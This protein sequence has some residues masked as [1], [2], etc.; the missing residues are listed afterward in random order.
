LFNQQQQ[1]EI[2]SAI[3]GLHLRDDTEKLLGVISRYIVQLLQPTISATLGLIRL[4]NAKK[5]D[6]EKMRLQQDGI[7]TGT[8]KKKRKYESRNPFQLLFPTETQAEPVPVISYEI[9]Y[10]CPAVTTQVL[11]RTIDEA[12]CSV[13]QLTQIPVNLLTIYRRSVEH[14]DTYEQIEELSPHGLNI[15]TSK[16]NIFSP[17]LFFPGGY[18]LQNFNRY[19]KIRHFS[20]L[21]MDVKYFKNFVVRLERLIETGH[22]TRFFSFLLR[23]SHRA[24]E[25]ENRYILRDL[26]TIQLS[27]IHKESLS[28]EL[29]HQFLIWSPEASSLYR[30]V[31]YAV[32]S[33]ITSGFSSDQMYRIHRNVPNLPQIVDFCDNDIVVYHKLTPSSLPRRTLRQGKNHPIA[34]RESVRNTFEHCHTFHK[35]GRHVPRISTFPTI[36]PPPPLSSEEVLSSIHLSIESMSSRY[37]KVSQQNAD[38]RDKVMCQQIIS[39]TETLLTD[40]LIS[41]LSSAHKKYLKAKLRR[42]IAQVRT[43]YQ[44][45]DAYDPT[46]SSNR[47]PFVNSILP[48]LTRQPRRLDNKDPPD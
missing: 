1:A 31:Q 47:R 15:V 18:G 34:V 42:A 48:F 14:P 36:P 12:I 4:R 10:G 39:D 6:L 45:A 16:E 19:R 28:S 44:E 17:L 43:V 30:I 24:E 7:K 38:V 41:N 33:G 9:C 2:V 8:D 25:V 29:L 20:P 23:C 35:E 27:V 46:L 37:D 5:K 40:E 13:S 22:L 32:A 26:Q 11:G 3:P 21:D